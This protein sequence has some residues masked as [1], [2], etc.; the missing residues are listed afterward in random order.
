MIKNYA[1]FPLA[2]IKNNKQNQALEHIP[3]TMILE[4]HFPHLVWPPSLKPYSK[5]KPKKTCINLPQEPMRL[6]FLK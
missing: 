6:T 4:K 5:F 2:F 1:L 3:S